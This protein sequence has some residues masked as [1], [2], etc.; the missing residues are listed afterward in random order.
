MRKTN[1]CDYCGM[2]YSYPL[3]FT[4]DSIDDDEELIC[5]DCRKQFENE[6]NEG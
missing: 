2:L 1:E 5:S 3:T 4:P 6:E